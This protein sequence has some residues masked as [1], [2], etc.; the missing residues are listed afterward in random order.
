MIFRGYA[1][2]SNVKQKLGAKRDILEYEV[3]VG[4]EKNI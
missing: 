2:A 4:D 1:E 3:I